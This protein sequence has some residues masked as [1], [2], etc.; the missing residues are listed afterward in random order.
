MPGTKYGFSKCNL[1]FVLVLVI[2]ITKASWSEGGSKL[3]KVTFLII[4]IMKRV[5]MVP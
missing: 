1:F 5:K 4:F 3:Q 2:V